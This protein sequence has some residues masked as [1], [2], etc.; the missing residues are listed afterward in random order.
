MSTFSQ[1]ATGLQTSRTLA[2][3]GRR[4]LIEEHQHSF[5]AVGLLDHLKAHR[6]VYRDRVILVADD[7][8]YPPD[9]RGDDPHLAALIRLDQSRSRMLAIGNAKWQD[10]DHLFAEIA[11]IPLHELL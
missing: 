5:L 9:F 1:S 10:I 8:A 6:P 4:F 2:G 3:G 11:D 7:G